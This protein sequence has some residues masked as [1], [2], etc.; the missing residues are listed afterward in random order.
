MPSSYVLLSMLIISVLYISG[1]GSGVGSGEG[2]GLVSGV[3]VG[4]GD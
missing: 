1:V 3:V 4:S 2:V